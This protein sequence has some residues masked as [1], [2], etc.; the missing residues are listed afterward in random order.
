MKVA[1]VG[2][3][4]NGLVSAYVL[5]KAGVEVV[6]F[7]KEEYLGG[8]YK[9]VNYDGFYLDL[10]FM[11]FNP[12]THPNTV[13]F[14]ENLGVEMEASNMSFSVSIDKG[15]GYEWSTRNGVLSLF[16]Q[17]KNILYPSFLQMIQEITK[18]KDEVTN[19]L[20]A[21]KNNPEM[22]QNETLGQFLKSR[23]YSEVFQT[24]YLFPMCGSIWSIP[25]E[26]VFNFSAVSVFSYLQD[27]YLLQFFGHP[28]WLTVKWSSDSYLKKKTLESEGCQI[29]TCSK[30]NSISTTKE[31]CIV[32]Y[33]L[34]FEEIFDQCVIATDAPDALRILGNQAT[35]EEARVLGA[36]QYVYRYIFYL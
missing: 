20:E 15:R 33:G 3:G 11:V 5:A 29:R 36:F 7:E 21:M 25:I 4:I 32:S 24:A 13:E 8:H 34:H 1:V 23:D 10:G 17:K 35:P 18:F 31:G 27:H 26:K 30:I 9:T 14:L 12:V 22:D 28:Q 6:L 16:A 2:A 19:Y